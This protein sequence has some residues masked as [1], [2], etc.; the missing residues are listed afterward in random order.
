MVSYRGLAKI[1]NPRI[2][3]NPVT[4]KKVSELGFFVVVGP[5]SVIALFLSIDRE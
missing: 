4:P 5:D 3:Q 1:L 2:Q